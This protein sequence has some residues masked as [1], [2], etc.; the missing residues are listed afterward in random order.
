MPNQCCTDSGRRNFIK[1]SAIGLTIAPLAN[2]LVNNSVQAIATKREKPQVPNL[3]ED[4]PQAK[5]LHYKENAT[6]ANAIGRED[7]QFCSNCQLY[8]GQPN[9][10]WGPCAIFSYR[11]NPKTNT[12]YMV[13]A[14]GWCRGWGP[15]ATE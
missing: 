2:L 15:R 10:E 9:E 12:P 6:T 5:A 14:Q 8:T 13:S 11:I 7:N 3:S 4:D 1:L